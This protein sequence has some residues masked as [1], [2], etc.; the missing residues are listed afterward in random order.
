MGASVAQVTVQDQYQ[1]D[2]AINNY[3]IQGYTLANRTPYS[4]TMVKRKEFS[5]LWAVIG[6]LL[7]L[8]PLLVYILV[9]AGQSDKVVEIRIAGAVIPTA[10]PMTIDAPIA[11]TE[12]AASE[13]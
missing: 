10:G 11:P 8:L 12:P 13:S 5:T 6:F 1:L 2:A 9:Y 7:C 4:A 3:V